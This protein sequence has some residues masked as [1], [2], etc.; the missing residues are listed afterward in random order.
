M[1]SLFAM[2]VDRDASLRA[3]LQDRLATAGFRTLGAVSASEARERAREGRVD[4]VLAA[5]G[6]WIEDSAG[7]SPR[8]VRVALFADTETLLDAG[9]GW[10]ER[11]ADDLMALDGDARAA[12]LVLKRCASWSEQRGREAAL[13]SDTREREGFGSLVGRSAALESIRERLQRLAPIDENLWI[14]GE[15]GVGKQWCARALHRLAM[16]PEEPFVLVEAADLETPGWEER[17]LSSSNDGPGPRCTL[18][19]VEPGSFG[20]QGVER[21][22]RLL[23]RF[24]GG[25]RPGLRIIAGSTASLESLR[26]DGKLPATLATMLSAA[27]LKMPPLRERT[28]DV[29]PLALHF[30][31]SI[32]Q[33]N[34]LEPLRL[35]ADALDQL[36]AYA[37]PG[38]VR[39]LRHAIEHAAILADGTIEFTHLPRSLREAE[40]VSGIR[41]A[42][43][44]SRPFRDAKGDVVAEFEKAYLSSLM[45][46][47]RGN[48]TAG[49]RE[50][51][52]LRSA[53]QRLLRKY[54]L[55]SAEFRRRT[56]SGPTAATR[57]SRAD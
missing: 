25:A 54:N 57:A 55:K 16:G 22:Q 48:V 51:G 31:R 5:P 37:W 1:A 7:W 53:L 3:R 28:E 21:L 41:K 30:I 23:L 52:M 12:D 50:A 19:L 45:T 35:S 43:L 11:G 20:S 17:W 27:R 15:P 34:Q 6:D 24:V 2:V 39:E 18:Y 49:A 9:P 36:E 4:L 8:P 13:R 14:E 29:G 33:V 38:N 26:D 44:A 32:E 46:R 47:E 42:D 40:A 56:P 10:L